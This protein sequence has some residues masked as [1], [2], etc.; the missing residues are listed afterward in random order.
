MDSTALDIIPN[1]VQILCV[2]PASRQSGE[3]RGDRRRRRHSGR[4]LFRFPPERRIET[5]GARAVRAVRTGAA[6]V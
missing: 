4:T 1:F 3:Q 5:P 2:W 6:A